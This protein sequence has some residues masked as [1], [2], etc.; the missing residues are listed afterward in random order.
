MSH[1]PQDGSA[2]VFVLHHVHVLDEETDD[3]DVKLIG[4]YSTR[5]K[6]EQA[7]ERMNEQPG[8]RDT[9]DGFHIDRYRLD[10]DNWTEGFITVYD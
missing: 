5:E 4:V 9:L 2:D 8:F 3:E 7:V 6:A 1:P 10:D